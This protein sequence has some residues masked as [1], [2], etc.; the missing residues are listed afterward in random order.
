MASKEIAGS[1]L[2]KPAPL[3]ERNLFSPV[4]VGRSDGLE[5]DGN[6]LACRNEAVGVGPILEA[7]SLENVEIRLKIMNRVAGYGECQGAPLFGSGGYQSSA[8]D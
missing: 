1:R 2:A 6:D 5:L 3:L 4:I 7:A 8:R